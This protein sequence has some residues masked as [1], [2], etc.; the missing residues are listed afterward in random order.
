[1]SIVQEIT[2][3]EA[4]NRFG[5]LIETAQRHPVTITKNGR[6]TVVVLSIEDYE[7]RRQS[8]AERLGGILDHAAHIAAEK[9]L[10]EAKLNELLADEN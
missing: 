5:K 8:A 9:G 4:K 1:M 6:A 3:L 10:T 2:A 7:R